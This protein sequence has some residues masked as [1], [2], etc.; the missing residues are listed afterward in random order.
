[1]DEILPADNRSLAGVGPCEARSV[2]EVRIAQVAAG[3]WRAV[4]EVRLKSL[5]DAPYAFSSTLARAQ[6]FDDDAWQ[7]RIDERNWFLARAEGRAVGVAALIAE[8]DRPDERHLVSMW[9]APEWRGTTVASDLVTAACQ[10][11][12]SAGATSVTLWV[13]DANPQARAFYHRL[14][15][16]PTGER[17]PIQPEAPELGEQRMRLDLK[18]APG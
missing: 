12:R 17:Q 10:C 7:R 15:F 16:R 1:V 14:G 4:R 8:D 2:A 5:A 11:A 6:A 9:V 18:P 3:D 13:A